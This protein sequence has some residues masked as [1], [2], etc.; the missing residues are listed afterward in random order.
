MT[1]RVFSKSLP[2]IP[3][4]VL[5]QFADMLPMIANI[6]A[7]KLQASAGA[8]IVRSWLYT[9]CSV[10]NWNNPYFQK[11]QEIA[12]YAVLGK[13]AYIH[14]SGLNAN[15]QSEINTVIEEAIEYVA[16]DMVLTMPEF[17]NML[18]DPNTCNRLTAIHADFDNKLNNACAYMGNMTNNP[19]PAVNRFQTTPGQVYTQTPVMQTTVPSTSSIYANRPT[20]APLTTNRFGN[21]PSTPVYTE[22]STTPA[23]VN[24]PQAIQVRKEDWKA[25]P[26]N[27][28]LTLLPENYV[29]SFEIV[30]GIV[31]ERY[32]KGNT[33]MNRNDHI[34]GGNIHVNTEE[35][36]SLVSNLTRKHFTSLREPDV[37]ER[38][39]KIKEF[40]DDEVSVSASLDVA[41]VDMRSF[42]LGNKSNTNISS[43]HR[44]KTGI[45]TPFVD[46][47]DLMYILEDLSNAMC[48]SDMADILDKLIDRGISTDRTDQE[49]IRTLIYLQAINTRLT[50]FINTFLTTGLGVETR[51][52]SFVTD[53]RELEGFLGS[54]YGT[55][56]AG[57]Y[58]DFEFDTAPY[59]LKFPVKLEE[60]EDGTL[61]KPASEG[62]VI[63]YIPELYTATFVGL[64]QQQLGIERLDDN[65]AYSV[66]RDKTPMIYAI[67]SSIFKDESNIQDNN[68]AT[69]L[70]ITLDNQMFTLHKSYLGRDLYVI[71]NYS[72]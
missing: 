36:T 27:P 15:V 72:K 29:R 39:L 23:V 16:S 53:I 44:Y 52:E 58:R 70:L 66:S 38:K 18:A 22:P 3:N 10:N 67:C 60:L 33:N 50:K 30:E 45:Y 41:I 35:A 61:I 48:F 5:N 63:N 65:R 34:I 25:T 11:L 17:Q 43:Y 46:N 55:T 14:T 40:V 71:T 59:V 51:I 42:I 37:K 26:V 20:V 68:I 8:N 19:I 28:Y 7:A 54:K 2:A 24:Q 9:N 62:V 12:T 1:A 21:K 4:L 56:Y 31:F 49:K 32:T 69:H 64:L 6:I 57:N 13:M 47:K